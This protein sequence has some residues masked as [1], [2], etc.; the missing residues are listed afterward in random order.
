[1]LSFCLEIRARYA[2]E[3]LRLLRCERALRTISTPTAD[4]RRGCADLRRPKKK[5]DALLALEIDPLV[6]RIWKF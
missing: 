6:R 2:P 1:M 5:L 3:G 4:S